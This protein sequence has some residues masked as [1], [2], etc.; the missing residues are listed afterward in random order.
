MRANALRIYGL[1]CL[2]LGTVSFAQASDDN[3]NYASFGNGC[4][5]MGK[6]TGDALAQTGE[7]EAALRAIRDNPACKGFESVFQGALGDLD[8]AQVALKQQ[9]SVSK[10]MNRLQD[11]DTQDSALRS[12]LIGSASSGIS[13]NDAAKLSVGRMFEKA[14]IV[15]DLASSNY[16]PMAQMFATRAAEVAIPSVDRVLSVLPSIDSC[17]IGNAPQAASLIM[18]SV[19]AAAAFSS[20][21]VGL[22]GRLS[23]SVMR[24]ITMLRDKRFS[25]IQRHL[26]KGRLWI[27][28][29]CLME[30]TAQTYCAAHD[31]QDV[32]NKFR[33]QF[34]DEKAKYPGVKLKDS[35]LEGYIVLT[36]EVDIIT[37]WLQRLWFGQ[38]PKTNNDADFKNTAM[39]NFNNHLTQVN[40]VIGNFNDNS[41]QLQLALSDQDKKNTIYKMLTDLVTILQDESQGQNFF[42]LS[43]QKDLIPFYLVGIDKVP[44]EVGSSKKGTAVDWKIYMVNQGNFI[45]PFNNPDQLIVTINSRLTSL[46]EDSIRKAG[47]Q[48]RQRV[49]TDHVDVFNQLF[50]EQPIR[51]ADAFVHVYN[52]LKHLSKRIKE[53]SDP[54]SQA[55]LPG[56][57][58]TQARLKEVIQAII[59]I[60]N[61]T[62]THNLA[63][64]SNT[65]LITK[66][67][68]P[69]V[70]GLYTKFLN[71]AFDNFRVALQKDS[72]FLTRIGTYVR[73]DYALR[74]RQ[75]EQM[76]GWV[77]DILTV[78]G[79][80]LINK[81]REF[82]QSE[83]NSTWKDL[84]RAQMINQTNL[85]SL[86]ALLSDPL[87]AVM[88]ELNLVA[89]GARPDS[90]TLNGS[91]IYH[92][93]DRSNQE[94]NQ[95]M[96][97]NWAMF[98]IHALAYGAKTFRLFS[99]PEM[100]PLRVDFFPIKR[101]VDDEYHS[102]EQFKNQ[103]CV[104]SL[105]F[106]DYKKFAD[107]CKG[108]TLQ[109]F[110]DT[111]QTNHA[112]L[113]VA[114]DDY[115]KKTYDAHQ[116]FENVCA[117]R[118]FN[119][120][121][122]VY[123]M[124]YDL[125]HDNT[126]SD[127]IETFKP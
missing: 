110:Y 8:T 111:P 44:D 46:Q 4:S 91:T 21:D 106:N 42:I 114:W 80:D 88:N 63:K 73:Y 52:Y 45:A 77:N 6:W 101:G 95:D 113:S 28:M 124:T 23:D 75:H 57:L 102:F 16:L 83:P 1:G 47:A 9:S 96:Q 55:L 79:S 13:K 5:T 59:E 60:S 37:K 123:W 84:Q 17:L 65:Q 7:M 104:Q 11:I 107:F 117:F 27:S 56:I 68:D 86:E 90:W 81:L 20:S 25:E 30:T 12:E 99:H 29:S 67:E 87:Y 49:I 100:Y 61:Y 105:A 58:S 2:I 19:K 40:K 53:S 108:S 121:N 82:F 78:S 24:I 93:F 36:R 89:K 122:L 35:P 109:S 54:A 98:P 26:D 72:F 31:A 43:V 103:L 14:S 34:V 48:Y 62:K 120:R 38:N 66:I 18:A 125:G 76:G 39:T 41:L 112:N 71:T 74:L 70:K 10:Q 32:L 64:L 85:E 33:D 115:A 94:L 119:R 126:S 97:K 22:G 116:H 92:L 50:A 3:R 51:T 127:S 15:A 69:T 118:N